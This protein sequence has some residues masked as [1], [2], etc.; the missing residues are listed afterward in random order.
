M[1]A[2]FFKLRVPRKVRFGSDFSGIDGW[3][4]ALQSLVPIIHEFSCDNYPQVKK[5]A[6]HCH[7]PKNFYD[8]I[9]GRDD[10][11]APYVDIYTWSPPC[12]DFSPAGKRLGLKGNK[13]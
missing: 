3:R 6:L 8:D 1:V 7:G 10:E 9:M 4:T 2:K 11:S 12:Q 13:K 5:M